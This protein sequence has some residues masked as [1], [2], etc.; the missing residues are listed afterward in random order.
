M[1]IVG[2]RPQPVELK[3]KPKGH[4]SE[5]K[6]YIWKRKVQFC[7]MICLAMTVAMI[8]PKTLAKM[9]SSTR[10]RNILVGRFSLQQPELLQEHG[11]Y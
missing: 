5:G 8:I 6:R 2:R 11:L 1:N 3:P 9:V 4:T 10:H 7:K